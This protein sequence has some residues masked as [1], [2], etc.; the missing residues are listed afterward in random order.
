VIAV[1]NV[2]AN[3]PTV[4]ITSL[5]EGAILT[6]GENVTIQWE[7]YDADGDALSYSVLYTPDNGSSWIPIGTSIAQTS[8]NWTVP[9]DHPTDQCGIKVIASDGV[10]TGED[11]SSITFT[12]LR[13]DIATSEIFTA[14]TIVGEGYALPINVIVQN[15][16]NFTETFDIDV[17]ANTTLIYEQPLTLTAGSISN[18]TLNVNTTGLAHCNYA[19]SICG[20][21]IPGETDTTDNMLIDGTVLIGVPCDVTGP[22]PGV[23]DSVCNMRDIGYFC[24]TFGC[25]PSDPDWDPNCDVTGPTLRVP[26]NAVNMRDIGMA[27]SNFGQHV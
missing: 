9:N 7:S 11:V 24:S 14:K 10:N 1:R 6:S 4:N 25:T 21:V 5:N 15:L 17:Y 18:L 8:I 16:G 22:T 2:S 19:M 23:P 27:C 26:D 20:Q 12:I 13:H 3:A